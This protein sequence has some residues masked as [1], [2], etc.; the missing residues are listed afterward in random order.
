M[1]LWQWAGLAVAAAVLCMVVRQQQPELA[2]LCALA[3]GAMLLLS[4]LSSLASVQEVFGRLMTLSGLH[5]GY[6]NLLLKILGIAYVGEL[7]A[8]TCLDLG[9][10]GLAMKVALC[11][12]LAIFTLAAPMLVSLLTMIAELAP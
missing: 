9:E 10:Q 7:A 4:A 3:A 1:G 11:G 8:Q 12:K 2:G 5:Q 6:M